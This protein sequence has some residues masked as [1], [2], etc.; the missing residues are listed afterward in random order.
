MQERIRKFLDETMNKQSLMD[1]FGAI[2]SVNPIDWNKLSGRTILV[3][4]ATG[5]IGSTLIKLLLYV[6]KEYGV[7]T[8]IIALIRNIDKAHDIFGQKEN[9]RYL[10]GEVE[11]CVQIDENV[12]YI[13]HAANPTS[14]TF[15]VKNPVETMSIAI[16]GTRNMLNIAKRCN[17]L[18]FVFLSSMEVY[19]FPKKG[20][21][22]NEQNLYGFDTTI[23]RNSY[24]ISKQ[25]CPL[26]YEHLDEIRTSLLFPPY[27]PKILNYHSTIFQS[28]PDLSVPNKCDLLQLRTHDLIPQVPLPSHPQ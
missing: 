18:G 25:A 27:H 14:S 28:R 16:D 24:P 26:L 17:A 4:G 19:G 23:I 20:T 6:G 10:V 12:D 15:F 5:L 2:C 11:N 3:T 8:T 9:I 1:D 13:V 7:D 21:I 22:M